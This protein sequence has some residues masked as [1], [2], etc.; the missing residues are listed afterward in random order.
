MTP[1]RGQS[2]E[3]VGSAKREQP[4]P[5]VCEIRISWVG[6]GPIVVRGRLAW[7]ILKLVEKGGA[8]LMDDMDRLDNGHMDV[9]WSDRGSVKVQTRRTYSWAA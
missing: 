9:E 7:L 5:T 3:F 8:H 4:S 6:G 2:Q 1:S